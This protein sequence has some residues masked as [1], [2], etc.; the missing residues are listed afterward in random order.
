MRKLIDRFLNWFFDADY[1][2]EPV[3]TVHRRFPDSAEWDK[4]NR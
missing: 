4:D 1:W 3:I 2:N